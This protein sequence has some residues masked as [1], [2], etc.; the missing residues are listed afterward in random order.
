MPVP[1]TMSMLTAG[2]TPEVGVN[3]VARAV[4]DS[5]Q[6]RR[7]LRTLIALRPLRQKQQLSIII[8]CDTF[9]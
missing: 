7:A 4:R 9:A 5:L 8:P 2:G 6:E 3:D 1:D